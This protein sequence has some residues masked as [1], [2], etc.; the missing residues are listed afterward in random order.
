MKGKSNFMK[1]GSSSTTGS[2]TASSP[3]TEVPYR[4]IRPQLRH[5]P[6]VYETICLANDLDPEGGEHGATQVSWIFGG[7]DWPQL[8]Q[9]Y[10]AGQF[11]A[12]T[13]IDGQ[14][15]VIGVAIALRTAYPPSAP[16]KSWLDSIGDL[17][18][19]GHDPAGRWL[20]GA[21]KAVHPDF[22]GRGIGT[23]L[24]ETQFR[25]ARQ[26]GLHGIYAGGMLKG[27]RNYRDTM[28][29][30]EYAGR[31]MRG[32]L[33]DPTVSVQM[34]RGFR[35]RS[36]IE[37]YSWDHEASHAGLLIVWEPARRSD[38]P[39]MPVRAGTALQPWRS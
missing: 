5:G 19:A 8:L 39:A 25:L 6:G 30:R 15:K 7:S 9:R 13:E 37:N 21:E 18:L 27:Y 12:V 4:I 34:K 1:E 26:L 35:P 38:R 31:V 28:S 36:L 10:G 11:I 33:F 23:A 2:S 3:T 20:Y 29:L 16:P 14:E 22:Q 17:S 24:Y 32:E